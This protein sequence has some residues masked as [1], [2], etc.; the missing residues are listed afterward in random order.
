MT[1]N[2]LPGAIQLTLIIVL[3]LGLIFLYLWQTWRVIYLQR[4]IRSIERNLV[5]IRERR[6]D[7][8]LRVSRYFSYE[9][10]E[11]VAKERLNM[12]EPEITA[13]DDDEG[14]QE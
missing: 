14:E 12:I 6:N 10:I 5:P 1:M 8:R 11:R 3:I 9:R 7:L 13:E 2:N 4:R